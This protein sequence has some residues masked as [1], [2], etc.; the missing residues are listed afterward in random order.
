MKLRNFDALSF[1]CYGTLIDWERGI[2]AALRPWTSR[3]ELSVADD[4]LL[5]IY[6]ELEPQHEAGTPAKPYPEILKAVFADLAKR[7]DVDVTREEL[8]AFGQSI[9]NWPAFD[10]SP[11]ALRYLKRHYKLVIISNVDQASFA[12]SNQ[13]LGVEF[14]AVVTAEDVGSYKPDIRNFE[15]ALA[16][17]REMGVDRGRVLHVAQSLF[18]DHV[19]A[20]A[21]GLHTVWINRRA[22]KPGTG[23]ARPPDVD[24]QP[25][26]VL[27]GLAELAT[28]HKA[29]LAC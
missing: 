27:S 1:D 28:A 7:L 16:R 13:K 14:D 21:L 17:L 6:A 19:P 24:V 26:L 9:R 29:E 23:A 3:H 18:H 4:Q 11:E 12:Y 20:K 25:D 5:A 2:V 22:G 10:D 8:Q 15:L